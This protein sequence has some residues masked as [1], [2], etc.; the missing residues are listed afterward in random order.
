V[1][2]LKH[3]TRRNES[4]LKVRLTKRFAETINGVD[5]SKF[6]PGDVLDLTRNDAAVLLTEG[7]AVPVEPDAKTTAPK[8]KGSPR[9]IAADRSRTRR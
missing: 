5:L 2:A 7:W 1:R 8:H 6:R 9:S 3:G 4:S